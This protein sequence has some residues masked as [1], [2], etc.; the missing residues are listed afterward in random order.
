MDTEAQKR[1]E[2]AFIKKQQRAAEA[3]VAWSEYK[4]KEAAV[5]AN[6]E[7]LRALRLARDAQVAAPTPPVEKS[8]P[9]VRRARIK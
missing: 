8:K 9:K 7:R 1:A 3:S 6:T 5:D 4:T 2:A